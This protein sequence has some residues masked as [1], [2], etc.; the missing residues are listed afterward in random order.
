MALP[1]QGTL[2]YNGITFD[3]LH[4]SNVTCKPVYDEAKR[5]VIY[6]E[7]AIDVTAWIGGSVASDA[8]VKSM[9]QALTAPAKQ[10][11][12]NAKG[13]D[14]SFQINGGT[15]V[16]DV[17]W[18]PTPELFSFRPLGGGNG[19]VIEW[20]CTA[21]VPDCANALTKSG[22]LALN[23][24][25]EYD[26]DKFGLATIKTSGY[27]QVPLTR[28][29]GDRSIP[30]S[31]MRLRETV[32]SGAPPGFERLNKTYHLS[33]DKG[34]LDFSYTDH[35][36]PFP[37]PKGIVECNVRHKVESAA[38]KGFQNWRC[39]ISGTLAVSP[40]QPKFTAWDRFMLVAGTRLR[41]GKVGAGDL[42]K[43]RKLVGGGTVILR[44]LSAE[45]DVF[46]LS[47]T[48]SVQYDIVGV[49]LTNIFQQSGLW[50][51]IPDC[52]HK[53]WSA[54]L[55]NTMFAAKGISGI[56]FDKTGDI[57]IDLCA[58]PVPKGQQPAAHAPPDA[59][60]K[61]DDAA[62]GA[63]DPAAEA[64]WVFYRSAF[65]A[66]EEDNT[67]RHKPLTGATIVSLAAPKLK[68]ED[69]AAGAAKVVSSPGPGVGSGV[70]DVVQRVSAPSFT[71]TFAGD[72]ARLM[73]RVPF[74]RVVSVGG[75]AVTQQSQWHEERIIE[76]AGN[77]PIYY[78]QWRITYI[79]PQVPASYPVPVNPML[80][81][82][83]TSADTSPG[84]SQ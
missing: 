65:G 60:L 56:D 68:P 82:D 41:G 33:K 80:G 62:K 43:V 75:V 72:A 70:S 81:S 46:G 29:A 6:T 40:D 1:A 57:I 14:S 44:G 53:Q 12:Y 63:D 71:V 30:D 78:L 51:P 7:F 55:K 10:L 66:V 79:L 45:E 9:R 18:G 19:A 38:G 84:S 31:A 49:T 2:S 58:N 54:S 28:W 59:E 67:I 50:T 15:Q 25:I 47:S 24:E 8:Q 5:T 42:P 34:R 61:R 21:R 23:Y 74:P 13:F 77:P 69:T 3:A 36:L 27:A 37:L 76:D 26:L 32:T 64:T 48:F 16:F 52:D 4:K 22:I 73:K 83:G 20:K 17:A 35:E 11:T 39:V